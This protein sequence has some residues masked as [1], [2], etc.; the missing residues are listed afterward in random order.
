M[1]LLKWLFTVISQFLKANYTVLLQNVILLLCS[2]CCSVFTTNL[3]YS[4][5]TYYFVF[6]TQKVLSVVFSDISKDKDIVKMD[7]TS[8]RTVFTLVMLLQRERKEN[9]EIM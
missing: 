2:H 9:E 4:S 6:Y 7:L 1:V 5:I 3:H 8:E